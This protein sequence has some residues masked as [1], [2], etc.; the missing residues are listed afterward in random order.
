MGGG[1]E[2]KKIVKQIAG[3]FCVWWVCIFSVKY[4]VSILKE[5]LLQESLISFDFT[6]TIWWPLSCCIGCVWR[7]E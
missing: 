6:R 5:N 7:F 3:V 2:I 4:S 1:G